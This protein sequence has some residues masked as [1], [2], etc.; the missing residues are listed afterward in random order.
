VSDS[1]RVP[2]GRADLFPL[3][4]TK[5]QY[6]G[7]GVSLEPAGCQSERHHQVSWCRH[8]ARPSFLCSLIRVSAVFRLRV[9]WSPA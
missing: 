8:F 1:G 5:K 9:A 7:L 2:A 3:E 4:E 6:A